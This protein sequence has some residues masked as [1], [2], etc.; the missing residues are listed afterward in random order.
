MGRPGGGCRA[1]IMTWRLETRRKAGRLVI[2]RNEEASGYS[3]D[4]TGRTKKVSIAA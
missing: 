1:L 4:P 2:A 3:T